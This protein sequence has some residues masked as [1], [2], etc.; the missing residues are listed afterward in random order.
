MTKSL[1]SFVLRRLHSLES[2]IL[3]QA[4]MAAFPRR[5]R[6]E[7]E[8]CGI[9]V[10]APVPD[11]IPH[12]ASPKS[13][14]RAAVRRTKKGVFAVA[15]ED[16]GEYFTP[17]PLTEDDLLEFCLSVPKLVELICRQNGIE[18][19]GSPTDV[20][21]VSV[22]QKHLEGF[23]AVDVYVSLTV[24]DQ[25]ELASRCLSLLK[26]AGVKKVVVLLSG[27]VPFAVD[28]R[29]LLD[30][31]GIVLI[32]LPPLADRGSLVIDW[33]S[34]VIGTVEDRPDGV[35]P[36]RTI[37][38]RGREYKCDLNKREMAF[39]GMALRDEEVELGRLI[40]RGLDAVWKQS[41]ANTR[42]TRN[43]VT[44]FLSRL[45]R[46]LAAAV[47]AFPFFF[48]LPRGRAS[49]TRTGSPDTP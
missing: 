45:N 12:P 14:R 4:E 3:R 38:V 31:R 26:P 2:P 27:P 39:L 25:S 11:E 8:R 5:Q 23:G 35:Y 30:A 6:T 44:Q 49:V 29:Q 22:G 21:L 19:S 34:Q 13:G 33:D 24:G 9:L 48:S 32:P 43:K 36:P 40:H 7:L 20:S 42:T 18:S 15:S 17:V 47:P 37:V 1:L 16:G 46:K 10:R 41:F 28:Q